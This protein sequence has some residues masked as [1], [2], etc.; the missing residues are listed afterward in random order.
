[1]TNIRESTRRVGEEISNAG[2]PLQDNQSP[3]QEQARLG[4]QASVNPSIMTDGEIREAFL[5]LTHTMTTNL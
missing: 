5:N 2:I 1:M 4:D 3:P